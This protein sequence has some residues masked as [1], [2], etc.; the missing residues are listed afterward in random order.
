MSHHLPHRSTAGADAHPELPTDALAVEAHPGAVAVILGAA[1]L[2]G[3]VPS[4]SLVRR[5]GWGI[6]LWRAGEVRWLMPTGGIGWRPPEEARVMR[7]LLLAAGVP[8]EQILLEDR[9]GST[10]D[11]ARR[12]AELIARLGLDDVILVS[13]PWHLPRCHLAFRA[14]GVRARPCR[15]CRG[16][17]GTPGPEW[18]RHLRREAAALVFYTLRYLAR[19]AGTLASGDAEV[20]RQP[21]G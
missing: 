17:D 10:W 16:H 8:A 3:G 15:V 7:D 4:G 11:S 9:A 18:R 6:D 12:C 2:E 14:F 20:T 19:R 21:P 5:V 1:V 13:D